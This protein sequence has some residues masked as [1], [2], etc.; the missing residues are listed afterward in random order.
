MEEKTGLNVFDQE[1]KMK[2][3]CAIIKQ[4]FLNKLEIKED[5]LSVLF[6]FS[7]IERGKKCFS[8]G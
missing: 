2:D 5:I 4:N 8:Y 7:Q 1:A 3:I 6:S